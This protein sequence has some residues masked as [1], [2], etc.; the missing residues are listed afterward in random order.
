MRVFCLAMWIVAASLPIA[1]Q[2]SIRQVD[3]KNFT[4]P[5]SH[6]LVGHH[7]LQ[8]LDPTDGESAVLVGGEDSSDSPGFNLQSVTYADLTGEGKEDAIVVLRYG[9]GNVAIAHYVYVYAVSSGKPELLA[10][11]HAGDRGSSPLLKAY[12]DRGQLVIELQG[13]GEAK[14]QRRFRWQAGQFQPAS[15]PAG[16]TR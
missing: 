9:T 10:L 3:F 1:A 8:W 15:A 4:Y 14:V 13:P 7:A 16:V 2:Q 12:G 6:H 5:V 11:C